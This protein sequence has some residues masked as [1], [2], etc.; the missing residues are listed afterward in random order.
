MSTLLEKKNIIHIVT[1]IVVIVAITFY[2]SA[3]HKKLLNH[4][5]NLSKRLEEQEDLIQKHDKIITQLIENSKNNKNEL[6]QSEY[7]MPSNTQYISKKVSKEK[8]NKNQNSNKNVFSNKDS[9]RKYEESELNNKK[10][11]KDNDEVDENVDD[12]END[13]SDLDNEIA[14]EL[15]ELQENEDGLK[16]KT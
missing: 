4:I 11:Y 2:F 1:E 9:C 6:Y 7:K 12:D 5:E 15:E 8:Y 3:K 16:K 10:M 13:S 14:K